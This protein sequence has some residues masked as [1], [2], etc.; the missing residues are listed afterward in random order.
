MTSFNFSSIE[1]VLCLDSE[2]LQHQQEGPT[3]G[4]SKFGMF[5]LSWFLTVNKLAV[6]QS[7][8][9]VLKKKSYLNVFDMDSCAV[10]K[11]SNTV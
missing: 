10:S 7:V 11:V 9:S 6:K 5:S 2:S 1:C 3:V 4:R 8:Y